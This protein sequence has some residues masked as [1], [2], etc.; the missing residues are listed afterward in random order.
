MCM[1]MCVREREKE[2][3]RKRS[4]D[5]VLVVVV[6]VSNTSVVGNLSPSLYG[7][8]YTDR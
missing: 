1:G 4:K 2:R 3:E 5:I 8:A 7:P 6:I